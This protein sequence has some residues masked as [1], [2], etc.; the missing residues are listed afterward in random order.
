MHMHTQV[1]KLE[2]QFN[3]LETIPP[4]LLEL[5]CLCEL[6]LSNNKLR[7]LPPVPHWS[8]ALTTLDLSHNHLTTIPGDPR[9]DSLD[10][11]NLSHNKLDDVPPCIFNF[12]T[13]CTLNLSYNGI[14]TLPEELWSLRNLTTLSLNGLRCVREEGGAPLREGEA[15]LS[16]AHH[17]KVMVLGGKGVGKSTLVSLLTGTEPSE[18][19]ETV[20]VR[21]QEW[22]VPHG[23][24]PLVLHL[25]DFSSHD[26][27]HNVYQCFITMETIYLLLFDARQSWDVLGEELLPWLDA[28][29]QGAGQSCVLLV[30]TH[31][32]Q[33]AAKG[34]HG[35]E[36][37]LTLK[38]VT[39]VFEQYRDRL[40]GGNVVLAG[41][42]CGHASMEGL[43][44][45]VCRCARAYCVPGTAVGR[46]VPPSYHRARKVAAEMCERVGRVECDP[47]MDLDEYRKGMESAGI[48]SVASEEELEALVGYLTRVGPLL[49]FSSCHANETYFFH[50]PGWLYRAL[51]AILAEPSASKGG[52]RTSQVSLGVPLAQRHMWTLLHFLEEHNLVITLSP[53]LHLLT[54]L[55]PPSSPEGVH[56]SSTEGRCPYVRYILLGATPTLGFW[57]RLLSSVVIA[58]PQVQSAADA[59]WG[60]CPLPEARSGEHVTTSPSIATQVY[61]W[62]TGVHYQDLDVAFRVESLSHSGQLTH[63]RKEGIL[64]MVSATDLGRKLIGRLVDMTTAFIN[65]YCFPDSFTPSPQTGYIAMEE[66]IPCSKCIRMGRPLPYEFHLEPILTA[67]TQG[68]EAIACDCTTSTDEGSHTSAL[69][70]LAPDLILADVE[71]QYHLDVSSLCVHGDSAVA[72]GTFEAISLGTY[73]GSPVT[74]K[75]YT[76]SNRT[77][78]FRHLRREALLL[79]TLDHPCIVRLVGIGTQT[80]MGVVLEHGP[81]GQLDK[82]LSRCKLHRV[83]L[84]RMASEIGAALVYLH[85]RKIVLLDLKASGV[86]VWSLDPEHLTHCKVVSFGAARSLMAC[87]PP[88]A[89]AILATPPQAQTILATLP[90]AQAILAPEALRSHGWR[91]CDHKTDVF[92]LGMVLYHMVTGQEP[93]HNMEREKVLLAIRRGRRPRLEASSRQPFPYLLKLIHQCWEQCPRKRPTA[94]EA[95]GTLCLSPTQCVVNVV[96]MGNQSPLLQSSC[97]VTQSDFAHFNI[98]SQDSEVWFCFDSSEGTNIATYSLHTMTITKMNFIAEN[99]VQSMSVCGDHVWVSSRAGVDCGSLDIFHIGTRERVHVAA[100]GESIVSSI[101]SSKKLVYCGTLEGRC[102]VFP[103]NINSVGTP[104]RQKVLSDHAV[105]GMVSD[106]NLLWVSTASSILI[107]DLHTL[108]PTGEPLLSKRGFVGQLKLSPDDG[109]MAW[110][111][112]LGGTHLSAWN[113]QQRCHLFD[114]GTQE[115]LRG[116]TSCSENNMVITAVTLAT[117]TVWVG[118][119]TGHILIFHHKEML[120]WFHPYSSHIKVLLTCDGFAVSGKNGEAV[121][122]T[123]GHGNISRVISASAGF[124][125]PNPHGVR[126]GGGAPTDPQET[127]ITWEAF[128]SNLCRQVGLLDRR[129]A[130]FCEDHHFVSEMHQKGIFGQPPGAMSPTDGPV[131]TGPRPSS[132]EH[133]ELDRSSSLLWS[134]SYPVP[135]AGEPQPP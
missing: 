27:Y 86:M 63:E 11:L 42:Q 73:K 58:I 3:Q 10:T 134:Y 19:P 74:V 105:E 55:L 40:Q 2:L 49:R 47:V 16:T 106:G 107:L 132:P 111:Y 129:S 118:M 36:T 31:L 112:R 87:T 32:D 61:F 34:Q 4:S 22:A 62:R 89:Q 120:L 52:L 13:L 94:G 67:L 90:Q 127:L 123:G 5:P 126:D 12:L 80:L 54:T 33:L 23:E 17:L 8:P 29:A 65:G 116:I 18:D 64:I 93:F 21:I 119:A 14:P 85:Q 88:Q 135:T 59:Q 50:N 115:H 39:R 20:H 91:K 37:D 81:L 68:M 99:Q 95:V 114:V 133:S 60:A 9:A 101:T 72:L 6:N 35:E 70:D 79:Q 53:Y 117:D 102:L 25:W 30:G 75:K 92:S 76:H 69:A 71:V 113:V 97:I 7:D 121:V 83:T 124:H 130:T 24:Q 41:L 108:V 44:E 43:K 45:T 26:Q 125:W 1:V 128:P 48:R 28:L 51:C 109:E 56:V 84:H 46:R 98:P 78:A 15:P 38:E 100:T 82:I 103:Q 104:P 122:A 96:H 131:M 77:H 57:T 110:S 66:I